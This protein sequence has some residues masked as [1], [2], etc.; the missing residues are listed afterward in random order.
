MGLAY[1]TLL[2]LS[3]RLV[4]WDAKT[5]RNGDQFV[6]LGFEILDHLRNDLLGGVWLCLVI[7][8]NMFCND[9]ALV[10]PGEN[11]SHDIRSG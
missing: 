2:W 5:V 9:A 10:E 8:S 11:V 6:P 1:I 7:E 4:G 3:Y